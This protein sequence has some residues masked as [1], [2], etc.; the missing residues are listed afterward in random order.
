[1]ITRRD[2]IKTAGVGAATAALGGISS[3]LFAAGAPAS[4]A[5]KIKKG[6]K[7]KVA[8]VG[9]GNRGE[10]VENDMSKTGLM[11]IVALCDVDMGAKHTQKVISK[12]PKAKQYKDFRKMFDEMGDKFEA[13]ICCV[14]DHAHFPVAM[15]A[16]K[17]GKHI[18]VEKPMAHT[19]YEAELL[20]Q[21]AA[22][23]PELATQ[24]GNQGHSEANYFQ[25]KTWVDEGIINGVTRIDA[26][27]NS[28]RRWHKWDTNIKKFPDAEPIPET[29]DWDMWMMNKLHRD[30]SQKIHYGN[31][32]CW[33]DFGM[34]ALGDWGA[35]LFDTAHEFLE[36]GLP[37]QVGLE[38]TSGHNDFFYPMESTIRFRFPRRGEMPACDLWWYDGKENKPKLPANYGASDYD[39]NIPASGGQTDFA[40]NLPPGKVIYGKD[41]TFKGGS[42][43]S[44]LKMIPSEAAME[45]QKNLPEVPE[46]TSNHYANFLLSCMGKEKTRSP[47]AVSGVLTQTMA[48]GVIAQRLNTTFKFDRDAK[49][50]IDNPFAQA[51]LAGPAPAQ[52]WEDYYKI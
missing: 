13:V 29:L 52:G 16:L 33:F 21:A 49:R 34:G 31:W 17:E 2:F 36:L 10:Q 44:T 45:A 23:R 32:R 39:P 5:A 40:G 27:M 7:V 47:F 12:W 4:V 41:I 43:G 26:H 3:P 11:E 35:H 28:D 20:M 38:H 51:L 46:S 37:Y 30:Y 42:H 19:F 22:A 14:P 6:E 25:F 24:M 9:I 1:M 8:F 18:Y 15:R 50:V 48:L